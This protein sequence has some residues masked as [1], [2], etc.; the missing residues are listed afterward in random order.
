MDDGNCVFCN[1]SLENGMEKSTIGPKGCNNI[2]DVSAKRGSDVR[3]QIK[4]VVHLKCRNDFINQNYIEA[5][6]R[7][8]AVQETPTVSRLRSETPTFSFKDHCIFCGQP[9]KYDGKKRGYDVIPVRTEVF[10][11]TI[12]Q[13]CKTRND[14]WAKLVLGRIEYARCLFANDTVYHQTCSSNFRT[15]KGVP[16]E[17]AHSDMPKRQ[18]PGRPKGEVRVCAFLEVVKYFEANDDEQITISDLIQKMADCLQGTD[19]E[20]YS[21]PYMKSKLKDHFGDNIMFAEINGKANV[22]TF[23]AKASSILYDFYQEQRQTDSESEMMRIVET[24]AKLIKTDIKSVVASCNTYPTTEQLS[25]ID[26]NL[27]FLPDSLHRFLRVLFTGTNVD[28]KLA[29]VGQAIMQATRPRVI[30]APL[31]FGLA[32]QMHHSFASRFIVDTLH[33]HGFGCSYSEIQ[34]FERS[35]AL[36]HGGCL[37]EKRPEQFVQFVADNVDHNIRTID[38]LNTFHGMGIIAAFTPGK[39]PSKPVPRVAVSSDD[40]LKVGR[41][42]IKY[43]TSQHTRKL[44]INY[45]ELKALEVNDPTDYVDLLWEIS[46]FL[47]ARRPA[48][49]GMMQTVHKGYHP[50]KSTI[51]FLPMIDMDPSDLSCILSTLQYV[52]DQAKYYNVAPVLTFDQPLFWKAMTII[53][54]EP[55]TSDLKSFVLRLGGLHTQMSF[56][57]C[58][59]HLMAGSGLQEILEIVYADNAVKHILSGKAIS[60]AIRGHLLVA[61]ALN[62]M[63][64]ANAFNLPLPTPDVD[65]DDSEPSK[66][67]GENALDCE[68]SADENLIQAGE[69]FNDLMDDPST[70]G[71]VLTSDALMKVADQIQSEKDTMQTFRTAKLWLQYMDMVRIL[72]RFIKAERTGNWLL[73]LQSVQDMLPYFAASGHNLY[74]K[75]AYIYLQTMNQLEDRQPTV[76]AVF[77]EGGHV[78]RR[79]DRY[80]AGLSTDLIIEQVLMRSI[81]TS[82]GLTRG[83]GMTEVQRLVWLLSMPA[84]AEIH[85]S[86]QELTQVNCD[87]SEQNKDSTKARMTRDAEDTHK[88]LATLRNLDPFG[89]EPSLH[90]LIS[91]VTAGPL[92]NVDNAREVG[93]RVLDSMVG[94][95]VTNFPF[96]RKAQAVTL[97]SK[98]AINIDS[99]TVQVDPQVLFQRLSLIA[100]NGTFENPASVFKYELCTHPPALFDRTAR[101]LEANKPVLGDALWKLVEKSQDHEKSFEGGDSHYVLDGGALVQRLPWTQ[102]YSFE[103]TLKMYVDYVTSKYGKATIVFDGYD[104]G[105]TTKDST[106]QRRGQGKGPTLVLTP[107]TLV[108]I[109]KRTSFPT[110]RTNR[111]S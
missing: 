34:K 54:S 82:G 94:N 24:A 105:P 102:G 57:G 28:T 84:C 29:S 51:L 78:I 3:V 39:I 32:S 68:N 79:S 37:P 38:G 99:E 89:P 6:L 58:I 75:S 80:W 20:P 64:V 48:W 95:S 83:R 66:E 35:A 91:G 45:Q 9:A 87:K 107:Q 61:A 50:A 53:E 101:L 72:Q 17:Y 96:Q 60:R 27:S 42:N 15:G 93:Q 88:V 55:S 71:N 41:I 25:S 11:A 19:C 108:T 106:H 59:G 1:Q 46:F 5:D 16:E 2:N 14:D 30:L 49:S 26:E 10:Q 73:H 97:G 69:L 81:K 103:R 110:M 4:Q 13:K 74:A 52:S 21:F 43:F 18:K 92:V 36:A 8:K 56:L 90:G 67:D 76:H 44:P 85:S 31:Q 77:M 33:K 104:S 111:S 47:R 62:T 7:K 65:G 98:T 23:C 100:T 63:L 22:V 40:I 109:K 70:I 86:M 12:T